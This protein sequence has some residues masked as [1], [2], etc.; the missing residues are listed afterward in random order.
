MGVIRNSLKTY[1]KK[2]DQKV[3]AVQLDLDTDGFSY[4]KWGGTQTC[5]AGDWLVDNN[6][7]IY[8]ISRETFESTYTQLSAGLYYKPAIVWAAQ[9]TSN[10]EIETHEGKNTLSAW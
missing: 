3:V 8:T 10:G 2:P 9:A 4:Q 6:G 5:K 7:E 1:R